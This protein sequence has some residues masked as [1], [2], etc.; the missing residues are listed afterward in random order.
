VPTPDFIGRYRIKRSL[1]AGGF[2]TVWLAHDDRLDDEVAIKVLAENWAQR[3]DL[4]ERFEQEARVLRRTKSR[5][6]VEVY[7]IDELPDGRP[8]FVMTYANGGSLADRLRDGWLPVDEALRYG[9]ELAHGVQDLHDAGVMHR[10]IKPS[11]VLFSSGEVLIADLGL[12][13]ELE[14]GSRITMA[15][16]TPGFMAP[17]Q[18]SADGGIDHRADIYGLAATIYFALTRHQP[19]NDPARPSELRPGLPEGTDAALMRALAHDP[20]ERWQTASAFAE[21]LRRLTETGPDGATVV[22]HTGEV[23]TTQ[24]VRDPFAEP[25]Q[26]QPS[27]PP[28]RR[29]RP[30][31]TLVAAAAGLLAAAAI[32]LTQVLPDRS[33]SN[34]A[35]PQKT[36]PQSNPPSQPTV[37]LPVNT[38][39]PPAGS[40]PKQSV[41]R[42]PGTPVAPP[43]GQQPPPAAK[44]LPGTLTR[45]ATSGGKD[46]F[47]CFL[48]SRGNTAYAL[49]FYAHSNEVVIWE[50]KPDNDQFAYSQRWQFWRI[51]GAD[52]YM[53]YNAGSQRCL[54]MDDGGIGSLLHVVPCDAK[55][56]NQ[57]WRWTDTTSWVLKSD[58]GTCVDV[59]NGNYYMGQKPFGYDCS[60]E[61]NQR[62]LMRP[63]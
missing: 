45:C 9:A 28:A 61:P 59:P 19:A 26:P 39:A 42:P 57:L 4:R 60:T 22:G 37:S 38:S 62:W 33:P 7:D 12:S 44:P 58:L 40:Q 27:P 34:A 32:V 6:V 18:A 54:S 16:G 23:V 5:R 49:D 47:E 48:F 55:S 43:P 15:A 46:Q 31:W 11:N 8:Y 2:A 29:R 3:L 51:D 41:A 36:V 17:E 20:A 53:V 24:H 52:A 10:D 56:R 1:G 50:E 35:E 63:T 21:V 30:K 25:V 14:R 13:R